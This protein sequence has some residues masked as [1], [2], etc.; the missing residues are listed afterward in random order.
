MYFGPLAG[1]FGAAM[2]SL[3]VF[4][5]VLFGFI[6]VVVM[7]TVSSN[8]TTRTALDSRA[9]KDLVKSAS[10]W[11]SRAAQD[12]NVLIGLMNANYAMAYLNVARSIGSDA[13]IEEHAGVAVDELIKDLETTQTYAIQRL[14]STCPSATPQ[15]LAAVHTGWLAK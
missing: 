6:A 1:L 7:W 3:S 14:T 15:G 11:N 4:K 2:M 5:W 10:Q 13:A 8:K 12:T 9:I